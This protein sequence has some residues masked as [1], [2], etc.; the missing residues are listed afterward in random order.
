[1][2]HE[3]TETGWKP[4]LHCFPECQVMS[5]IFIGNPLLRNLNYDPRNRAME[6]P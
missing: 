5:N 4:I 6:W 3:I 2:Q 1:M